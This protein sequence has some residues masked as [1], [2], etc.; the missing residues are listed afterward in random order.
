[1]TFRQ[2]VVAQT[3]GFLRKEAEVSELRI[4]AGKAE[5]IIAQVLLDV[6]GIAPADAAA[7]AASIC[8]RLTT[9]M[10]RSPSMDR[11]RI[12]PREPPDG[13]GFASAVART[14][15]EGRVHSGSATEIWELVYN[16]GR[17]LLVN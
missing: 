8:Q 4:N 12:I 16:Q 11:Y 2:I 1:V 10:P 13:D 7:V 6:K 14:L 9:E 3:V 17:Y 5:R 15:I